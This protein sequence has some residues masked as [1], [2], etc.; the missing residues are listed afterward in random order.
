MHSLEE[1]WK[2]DDIQSYLNSSRRTVVAFSGGVDS[3]CLLSLAASL[4]DSVLALHV[5]HGLYPDED[6]WEQLCLQYSEMLGVM[7]D[8]F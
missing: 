2:E 6:K 7:F 5:N 3:L 8:C 4:N 1:R